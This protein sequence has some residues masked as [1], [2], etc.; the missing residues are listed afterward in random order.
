M[1]NDFHIS[2]DE[3]VEG[4]ISQMESC[5]DLHHRL[6]VFLHRDRKYD[7]ISDY[8]FLMVTSTAFGKII[9][10]DL[11]VENNNVIIQ[12][13]DCTTSQVGTVRININ[14]EKPDIYFIC[15][16]DIRKMVLDENTHQC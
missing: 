2:E 3:Q 10:Q 14:N 7:C 15:W 13:F 9:V 4:L 5:P 6:Q 8:E 11:T 16:Q 12:I 1:G